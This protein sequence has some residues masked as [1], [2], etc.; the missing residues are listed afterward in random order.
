MKRIVIKLVSGVV[1]VVVIMMASAYNKAWEKML[2]LDCLNNLR[3][4]GLICRE[5]AATHNGKFPSTWVELNF[6]GEYTNCAK[7][8]CCPS[9]HHEVGIWTRVDAWANYRLLPDRSTNDTPDQILAIEP[10]GNHGS[11][12]ANVLFVDGGTAWWSARRVLEV[13]AETT[14]NSVTKQP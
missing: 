2:R 12:G 9:T 10:L 4:L 11:A 13:T 6:V 1:L 3:Q 8:L 14:A 5:Y 7:L